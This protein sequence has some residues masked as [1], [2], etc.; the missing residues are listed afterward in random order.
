MSNHYRE[1]YLCFS[2]KKNMREGLQSGGNSVEKRTWSQLEKKTCQ[3]LEEEFENAIINN[4]F[5][6]VF[7]ENSDSIFE[8]LSFVK[9]SPSTLKCK[10]Q[11]AL[12][13]LK[14]AFE[15]HRY[16]DL[17]RL[18]MVDGGPNRRNKTAFSTFSGVVRKRP[19]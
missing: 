7:E 1:R 13:A 14:G 9:G 4:P 12:T 18:I 19:Q 5:E 2:H 3:Q 16:R 17:S 8:T 10:A 11:I 15:K 6:F